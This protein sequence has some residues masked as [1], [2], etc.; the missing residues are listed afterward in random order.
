V[1]RTGKLIADHSGVSL[2]HHGIR[3]RRS[4]T[5]P[6]PTLTHR[7]PTDHRIFEQSTTN[8]WSALATC[9]HTIL[10]TSGIPPQAI[11]GIGFDATCSLAAVDKQGNALSVSR[12]GETEEQE[13]D[14]HLGEE[15]EWNVILWADHRAEEEAE[16]INKTGEGVL[17]F[18]GKTMSVSLGLLGLGALML[19]KAYKARS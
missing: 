14:E 8:I 9:C 1:D 18:V 5:F 12:T 4:L 2:R 19:Y 6:E 16:E 15:G 13:S 3:D 7:S 17:E 10:K 11:K